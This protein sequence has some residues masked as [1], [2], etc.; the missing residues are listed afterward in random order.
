[1]WEISLSS[2]IVPTPTNVIVPTPTNVIVPTPTTASGSANVQVSIG[3]N[4]VGG[5]DIP[6][7]SSINPSF[8]ANNGPVKIT[9]TN[10][11]SILPSMQAIWREPG[12]RSSYSELMGLPKEQLS[13]E[14]WFP[15]YNFAVPNSMDQGL[16]I[17]VP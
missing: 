4:H 1:M 14:Y 10:N 11:V 15:W 6:H 17:S 13:T 2:V 16:R 7:V 3:N 12:Y 5:F 9:S 8:A